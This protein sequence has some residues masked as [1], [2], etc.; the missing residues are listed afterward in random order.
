MLL[1]NHTDINKWHVDV[2]LT[3]Q[4]NSYPRIMCFITIN[5]TTE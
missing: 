4:L 5:G 2:V 1:T 3:A